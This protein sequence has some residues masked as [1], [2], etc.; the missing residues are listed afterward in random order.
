M[1]FR[2]F[3]SVVLILALIGAACTGSTDGETESSDGSEQIAAAPESTTEPAAEQE[4]ERDPTAEPEPELDPT[5]QPEP[6]PEPTVEAESDTDPGDGDLVSG[7]SAG[8]V[9]GSTTESFMFED[10]ERVFE[11]VVPSSYDDATPMPVVLNWHGL[12]SNGPDQV[13]FSGY[14]ALAETE[15][16]I[17]IAPT[18]V[19]SPGDT[20]NSW[21]LE[22]DQ[23]P[24]RD[25]LAFA[26]ELL[27]LVI[28]SLC[29]D[30]TRVYTTGM[31]NGGYFSSVL[32]CEM[33]DRIAAA[34]SV[35]A[36][37]HADDCEPERVVPYI[38]F[39]GTDD[40][41]VPYNGGGE[42]SLAP[43]EIVPL[44]ELK[45]VDEFGEFADSA[46]CDNAPVIVEESANVNSYNY[47]NCRDDIEMTFYEIGGA[48]H[49][50]PGSVISLAI[51]QSAGLGVTTNEISAS[52]TSWT[53]FEQYALPK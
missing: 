21:E 46:G 32:V 1:K 31:S 22:P 27:D 8:T 16:F 7:C 30:Q 52:E 17:V 25:D 5:A 6:T 4:P 10:R 12:G 23:D 49:T 11:Q 43:G 45:I 36:L 14:A 50:W 35:A 3:G 39:H 37:S 29:V 51:S 19:P 2:W 48:G 18:G 20:R 47:E 15:G 9:P 26:N 33:S 42:S 13:G 40:V 53:F 28:E 41:V 38:G 24:T 44:F 34:A